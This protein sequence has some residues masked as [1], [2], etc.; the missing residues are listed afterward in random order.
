MIKIKWYKKLEEILFGR[1]NIRLVR[2]EFD[3][4]KIFLDMKEDETERKVEG[5]GTFC[6]IKDGDMPY[7]LFV[8]EEVFKID[9]LV[10][11]ANNCE[12]D[13]KDRI[14]RQAVGPIRRFSS[15]LDHPVPVLVPLIPSEMGKPY[16][17][18]L[19]PDMF[20]E[21]EINNI[22]EK[23]NN[24][25]DKAL[26]KIKEISGVELDKKVFMNG[27][28][29]SGV[30][31]QRFALFHPERIDTLFVG[32]AGGSIPVPDH[33]I[34]YPLGIKGLDDFD[35]DS[36]KQIKFKYYI[37]EYENVNMA[38]RDTR[39]NGYNDRKDI[40]DGV[41]KTVDRP[42][43]DMT[44]FPRSVPV[45]TGYAYR[46]KYGVDLFDRFR[47][48]TELYRKSGYDFTGTVVRGRAHRNL[49]VDG[50]QYKGINESF[51]DVIEA[52]YYKSV[53]PLRNKELGYSR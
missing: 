5:V 8:P 37:G 25:I 7:L 4:A 6:Y 28:S 15:I 29:S 30:F 47:T 9:R 26:D 27:Y 33:T 48:I 10:V 16:Y 45:Y 2:K 20:Y 52:A 32:G 1:E 31:A 44:Y 40:V 3:P 11:E 23:V 50:K 19:S 35:I 36:Y 18:Q 12:I 46:E 34:E 39:N 49:N 51:D 22:P 42:M 21:K 38:T 13:D 14:I 24:V 17:Q 53:L 41:V 43:H